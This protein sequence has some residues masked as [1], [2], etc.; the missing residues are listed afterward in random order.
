MRRERIQELPGTAG[1][2]RRELTVCNATYAAH[3][4]LD[5][6]TSRSEMPVLVY[7]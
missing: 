3:E 2:L 5:H 6:V 4:K 7:R 1:L